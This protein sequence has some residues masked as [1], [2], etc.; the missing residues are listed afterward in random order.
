[1]DL[2]PGEMSGVDLR[3][4]TPEASLPVTGDSQTNVFIL[5]WAPSK[6][7]PPNTPPPQPQ[8][9]QWPSLWNFLTL[10]PLLGMSFPTLS[11]Y[12]PPLHSSC[13]RP[14][15]NVTLPLPPRQPLGVQ[16][17]GQGLLCSVYRV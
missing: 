3:L 11:G 7:W 2:G 1:M 14:S 8:Y 6:A 15:A 9:T 5:L 13:P 4:A 17:F 12:V 16:H 10:V